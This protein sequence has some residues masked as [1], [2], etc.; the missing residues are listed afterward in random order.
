[1]PYAC[2][3]QGGEVVG[4]RGEGGGVREVADEEDVPVVTGVAYIAS[5]LLLLS[6]RFLRLGLC[7]VLGI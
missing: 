4:E 5:A 6:P 3:L 2:G 7:V 1:M